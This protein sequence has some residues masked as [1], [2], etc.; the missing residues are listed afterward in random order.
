MNENLDERQA[1]N[2]AEKMMNDSVCPNCGYISDAKFCVKC[3][4]ALKGSMDGNDGGVLPIKEK[5]TRKITKKK[6]IIASIILAICTIGIILVLTSS[7]T[8][9]ENWNFLSY[10]IPNELEKVDDSDTVIEY[11]GED[12]LIR[13]FMYEG[14]STLGSSDAWLGTA[15]SLMNDRETITIGGVAGIKGTSQGSLSAAFSWNN[16]FVSFTLR[17]TDGEV[18]AQQKEIFNTFLESV[19]IENQ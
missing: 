7:Q 10:E 18:N 16:I 3:G 1:L 17:A 11:K 9:K 6:V 13:L 19:E 8:H 5:P 4:A 2:E 15:R 12:Y 14:S